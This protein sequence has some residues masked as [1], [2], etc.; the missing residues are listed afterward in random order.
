MEAGLSFDDPII[1]A[2]R[3]HCQA[4]KRGYSVREIIAEM[5]GKQTGATRGKGGSMHYYHKTNNFYGGNGIVGAQI[6]VGAGIAFALKYQKKKNVCITMF[7]DGAANQGQIFEAA[8]M[9]FL[10]KLPLIFMC[11]NNKYGMGTSVERSSMNTQFYTRGG[12]IPGIRVD[13]NDVFAVREIMKWSK[14][15]CI[16]EGPLFMEMM[17][18]RYHGHSMSDPG[19]TYRTRDEVTERRKQGDPL[20]RLK[21]IILDNKLGTEE[22]IQVTISLFRILKKRPRSTSIRQ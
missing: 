18:Y 7:G 11:E 15:Y 4:Y 21:K 19:L 3:I 22:E 16:G 2:Y 20:V 12:V 14:N 5:L 13:G 1:A 6:P 9:S 10:W 17:T 8:N